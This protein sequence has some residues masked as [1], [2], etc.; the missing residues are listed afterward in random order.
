MEMYGL[1]VHTF[2]VCS[3]IL[4]QEI[5]HV[6]TVVM[7]ACLTCRS[8]RELQC[9]FITAVQKFGSER[10]SNLFERTHELAKASDQ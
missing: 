10:F 8:Y 5:K 2:L 4:R 3:Y 7:A 1:F 9:V 6:F